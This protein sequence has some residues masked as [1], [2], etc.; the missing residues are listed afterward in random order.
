MKDKMRAIDTATLDEAAK[1]RA[2][3]FIR[4][5]V[6]SVRSPKIAT[7]GREWVMQGMYRLPFNDEFDYLISEI[8]GWM[9]QLRILEL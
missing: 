6:F 2:G 5:S 7:M 8:K 1:F 4:P 3:E 9:G